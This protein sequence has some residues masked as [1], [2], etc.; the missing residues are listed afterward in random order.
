MVTLSRSELIML[1]GESGTGKTQG[2]MSTVE[3]NPN[4]TFHYLEADRILDPTLEMFPNYDWH[5]LQRYPSFTY[6]EL[7]DSSKR[8]IDAL[9]LAREMGIEQTQWVIIDTIGHMYREIQNTF[10]LKT[11]HMMADELKAKRSEKPEKGA[12]FDNYHGWEWSII[13]RIT[14]NEFYFPLVRY[15]GN[16]AIIIAHCREA[17]NRF[18]PQAPTE[19][20]TLFEELGQFPDMHKDAIKHI[21]TCL[22]FDNVGGTFKMRTLK[23]SG[24]RLW[25]PLKSPMPF[26]DFWTD[27]QRSVLVA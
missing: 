11:Y 16:N 18:S 8:V 4:A 26:S 9:K 19:Y 15:F 21:H 20:T 12:T 25:I 22:Y 24:K 5:N 6:E 17:G 13:R 14:Y 2:A 23:E 3:K 7:I 1:F 10:T 27:Y